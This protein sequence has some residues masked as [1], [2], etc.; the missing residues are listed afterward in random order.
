MYNYTNQQALSAIWKMYR[1]HTT[2]V[3][4]GYRSGYNQLPSFL[5]NTTGVRTGNLLTKPSFG[6]NNRLTV[7]VYTNL[8]VGGQYLNLNALVSPTGWFEYGQNPKTKYLQFRGGVSGNGTLQINPMKADTMG[9]RLLIN[10]TSG[11]GSLCIIS[12]YDIYD[13]ESVVISTSL[14]N[15]QPNAN[16]SKLVSIYV[17]PTSITN[18][19]I[20]VQ[21]LHACPYFD[22]NNKDAKLP[23]F[24]KVGRLMGA[25]AAATYG[26][27]QNPSI[28][29]T[30]WMNRPA[31]STQYAV[32][33]SQNPNT[34]P[35]VGRLS[36]NS[37]VTSTQIKLGF[38]MLQNNPNVLGTERN[39]FIPDMA[40]VAE[41]WTPNSG[42][43]TNWVN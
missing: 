4:D 2:S 14:A 10:A 22:M 41:G 5:G 27:F 25:T 20:S 39:K 15:F 26:T 34:L 17:V 13:R 12:Y 18:L 3:G 43:W 21:H 40:R 9:T 31:E 24:M 37:V 8:P 6:N 36:N 23:S 30:M 1:A 19:D 33:T 35:G 29:R 42:F 7:N 28:N 11:A 32:S 16:I 38:F